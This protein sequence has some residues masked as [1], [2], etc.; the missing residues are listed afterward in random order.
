MVGICSALIALGLWLGIVW[1]RKRDIPKTPWFLRA[2]AVSGVSAVVAL[3]CGWIVTE[4]GRQPWV[5]YRILRT[6]DA[7]TKADGVWVTFIAGPA[8]LRRAGR[9]ARDR[10]SARWPGA[11]ARSATRTPTRP[12]PR[13][14]TCRPRRSR[15][16]HRRCGLVGAPGR[17]DGLRRVRRRGLRRRLLE[18]GRRRRRARPARARADRLGDRP[19]LGG[20]PRLADLRARRPVDGLLVGVRGDLLDAL[21]PAQP[22][23][24]GDRA[25]RR[26]VRLPQDRA[27]IAR[28]GTSPS[29]CSASRR[30]SRRSSWAPS[31]APIASGRVPV[32]NAT[33]D[34]V[35]EL[36]EP[37][38]ARDRRALRRHVRV[39]RG[40]VPGQRRP[41]RR[42]PRSRALLQRPRAGAPASSRVRSPSPASSRCGPTRAT[43]TTASP[44]TRSRS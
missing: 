44:A 5:V 32:G 27:A 13:P 33:G 23:G 41:P 7:V 34:P 31:S 42:R 6:E 12:M 25:A 30:C 3:E 18:P 21:H 26:R 1:W 39:P 28:A 35:S 16:E 10:R 19:G 20:Q 8:P 24:A 11:G 43:S 17:R 29:V 36:A 40:G 22:G 2:V 15:H 14:T 37:A 38:L 9:G 4:V